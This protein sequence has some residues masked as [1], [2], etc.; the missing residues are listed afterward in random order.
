MASSGFFQR[1]RVIR[2]TTRDRRLALA[3]VAVLAFLCATCRRSSPTVLDGAPNAAARAPQS[4]EVAEAIYDGALA[5]GW[6]DWGWAT[7]EV[8][9]A[10]AAR[11]R[12]SDNGGWILAKPGL[13]GAYGGVVFRVK[14]PN[15]QG[16]FLELRVESNGS[17]IFPRVKVSAQHRTDVGDGWTEV[18]VPMDQLNPDGLAFDRVILRALRAVS[19]DWVLLD[20]IALTKAAGMAATAS[21]SNAKPVRIRI[22]CEARATKISPLIY[23][24]GG[25]D[26]RQP[27]QW[28]MGATVHRWGGNGTSRYNWQTSVANAAQDWF[29]EN[30]AQPSYARFLSDNA[31]HETLSALTVPM[32]GWVAKDATSYSFPVTAY[33]PQSKT[34]PWHPD[35]GNGTNLSGGKIPPGSPT[36]TSIPAPPEWIKGWISAIVERDAEAGK[37]S[38]Y[39]YILDNEP[40]LWNAT[41]RDVR[42]EP[43]G[44]DELLERTIQYGTAIRQA[45]PGALIAGPAEWGWSGY[46]F[47][48]KDLATSFG[49]RPDRR[50]HENVGLVEWY[51]RKLR[52][53]EQN[54]GV[55]I[56]DVLDLHYYPQAENVYDNGA[57]GSDPKTA[58]LRLRSTR[59]LWDESYVDESWINESVHLLPRMRAWIDKNYP[60]RAISVGEWN[61]G[62]EGHITGALATAE[63]LGRFAQ[64]GV[65][66]AFY[67]AV[68]PARSPTIQGFLTYRDF[69]GKGGRFLDWYVPS[70]P[71]PEMSLFVSRDSEGKH[72]VAVAVNMSPDTAVLAQ[73]DLHSC[74]AISSRQAY[75]YSQSAPGFAPSESPKERP[76]SASRVLPPWS[77]TVLAIGLA[78]PLGNNM[79]R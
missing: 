28:E 45:D 47:S 35:V 32:L 36:R 22:A 2:T 72:L 18:F 49:T 79:E 11:I 14:T 76:S 40:M 55:R 50:A 74:G 78:A 34:D 44:Y 48:A 58:A 52:E 75:V 13:T 68:P 60:G 24:F 29:F 30:R 67:W 53:H 10:G 27:W 4:L 26:D 57:G 77:I 63:A 41:H 1:S 51:L 54:T 62:G 21:A 69:D 64:F 70:T 42:P 37:R 61:F 9:E 23:G 56:L 59:S 66:S 12:F 25:G 16:D 46:F 73:L 65:T 5:N 19:S 7:R 38:V 20:K 15:V 3:G 6:Q 8:P 31:A 33:G 71:T 43:L 17:A 39:E